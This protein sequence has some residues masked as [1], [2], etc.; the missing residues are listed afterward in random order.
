VRQ[1]PNARVLAHPRALPHLIDPERL[2]QASRKT[3]GELALRYG[4]IEPVPEDRITAAGDMMKLDLGKGLV[5][6]I[7]LTPGH[8][9][10]HMSIFD[11]ANGVLLAGEAAGVCVFDTIRL[12][13]PPPFK[14]EETLA[15]LDRL[16]ALEP[17]RICYSHFGCYDNAPEKLRR[18]RQKLLDW[19][20]IIK[21]A[22]VAG[23]EPE[24]VFAM[25]KEKDRSLD[26]LNRLTRDQYN[27]EYALLLNSVKGI[28]NSV[29]ES[30]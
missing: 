13:T 12:T 20:E 19:Y 18:S 3:L 24:A 9:P 11:R 27:R 8:A 30:A 17:K 4:S 16:I 1:L 26:Y 22:A 15:S 28:Y 14:L 7:Y 10:H 6:E 23:N 2:W 29:R 5:L 21:S 25:L